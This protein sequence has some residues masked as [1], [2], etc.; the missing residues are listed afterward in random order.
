MHQVLMNLVANARDAMPNGGQIR[1]A[2]ANQKRADSLIGVAA[3]KRQGPFVLLSV[4]DTGMGMDE[5]TLLHIFEPFFTTKDKTQ[6]TGLGLSTV[7]SIVEQAEGFI[8]VASEPGRGTTFS[9]FLPQIDA[10]GADTPVPESNLAAFTGSETVLVVEDNDNVRQLIAWTLRSRGFHILD[11]PNGPSAI[12]ESLRY[13]GRIDLLVTDVIMPGMTGREVADQLLGLRPSLKVL[14]ISGYS[15]EVIAHR[16]ILDA[17]VAYL[18]KPF[19][20]E[21]LVAKVRDVLAYGSEAR[22]HHV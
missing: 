11:A 18:P 15:G 1:I 16:G 17:N 22:A 13:A 6:G 20:P 4:S 21:E 12:A 10:A 9:I 8:R 3:A 7:Y 14:F 19:T 5:E 2:T